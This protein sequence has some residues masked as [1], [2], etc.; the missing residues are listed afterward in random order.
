MGIIR[1]ILD[2]DLYKFTQQK[3]VLRYEADARHC[4][5]VPVKYTFNNRRPEGKFNSDFLL[6]FSQELE[7]M[8]RLQLTDNEQSYLATRLP[9]LGRDYIDFLKN[10]RF[11]LSEV[12]YGLN[13]TNDLWLTIEG[14]WERTILWEVPLM[15]LISELFFK[16]CD[17][18]WTYDEAI[19]RQQLEAKGEILNGI[20][21]ADFGTRRRR[22]FETQFLAVKTLRK[23]NGF[24]GTSNVHL[25]HTFNVR[26][27]GTM[28]HEWI[29]GI[30]ALESLRHANRYALRIWSDVWKGN[31]GIA[32]PDTFGVK[33]FVGD[34]D[35]YLARLFDG[36]RHDSGDP[37]V[38]AEQMIAMYQKLRIDPMTKILVFTDSLN[39]E[40]AKKISD[41]LK[42]RIRC[43]FGIGTNFTNDFP[44]SLPL[45]MVIKLSEVLGIPV[46][47][48]PD[49]HGKA[50]GDMD[51]QRIA[52]W[53]F[54]GMAL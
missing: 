39:P 31:L 51:A 48:M 22:S 26:P 3:A 1:S 7:L 37:F 33:A 20:Q 16:C 28:A 50:I 35:D 2:N 43:S 9:W 21:F 34:F 36:I 24:Y 17:T 14:P 38:F 44:N 13:S 15:S 11:D 32:L 53:M 18:N 45:N 23:V 12:K 49:D 19:Q 4:E 41:A 6:A 47:K 40:K 46:V 8:S 42:G 5:S 27:I 25:A 54:H 52:R 10:Y 30:S 29:M